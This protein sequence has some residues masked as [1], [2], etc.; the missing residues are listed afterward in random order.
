MEIVRS[1]YIVHARGESTLPHSNFLRF[2][3][4]PENRIMALPA[5]LGDGFEVTGIKWIASFPGNLSLGMDRASALV[6]LNSV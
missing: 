6:I 1:A 4:R 5:Y 2:P 3:Y